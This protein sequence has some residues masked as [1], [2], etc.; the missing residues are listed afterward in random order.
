MSQD[1]SITINVLPVEQPIG[2][3][4]IGAMDSLDLI[5]ISWADIRRIATEDEILPPVHDS[6]EELPLIDDS[7]GPQEPIEAMDEDLILI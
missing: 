5:A 6:S 7:S 4:Y 3:F 1:G 2:A